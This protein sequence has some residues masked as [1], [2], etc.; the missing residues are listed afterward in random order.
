M[1]CY[2]TGRARKNCHL[3]WCDG[4]CMTRVVILGISGLDADLLRVYGPSLPNL[5]R[6]LLQSPFLEMRSSFPPEPA[7]AWASIYTGQHPA[8]H[9]ILERL[10]YHEGGS[11]ASSTPLRIPHEKT[12]WAKASRA[13]KRVCIVNPLLADPAEALNGI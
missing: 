13:G 10:D 12:F 3:V 5:R 9:G 7:P 2:G 1:M 4:G 11:F 8:N 6:L